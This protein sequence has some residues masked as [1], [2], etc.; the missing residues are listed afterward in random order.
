MTA[1]SARADDAADADA[2]FG[3][4]KAL[5]DAG[6]ASEACPKLEASYDLDP[7]L[8]TLVNL[9]D[10]HERASQPARAF[11]RWREA[12]RWPVK[13]DERTALANVRLA[14]LEPQIARVTL[15]VT[16]GP[17]TLAIELDGA[18]LLAAAYAESIVDPGAHAI[19]VL[20]GETVLERYDVKVGQGEQKTLPID[21]A[22]IARAHPIAPKVI[23]PPAPEPV[24]TTQRDIGF[25]FGGVGLGAVATFGG[26]EIA[27]LAVRGGAFGPGGCSDGNICTPAGYERLSTAGDL[28]EAGQ[29]V[30]LAGAG[31]LVVGMTLLL[32]APSAS[33]Q[34]AP[35]GPAVVLRTGMLA[36][37][38]TFGLSL[39]GIL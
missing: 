21:L 1:S 5:L 2:L 4:A 10:C 7:R 11:V 30:G 13:D 23:A 8:G 35:A 9:A 18:P 27:A 6:K 34:P 20:R 37:G 12:S 33:S 15:Q 28:A 17:E 22:A 19:T 14:A 31:L 36:D 24:P 16:D 39:G 26:L 25:V 38:A 32:T 3:Q 29:W